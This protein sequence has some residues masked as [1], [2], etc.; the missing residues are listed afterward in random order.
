MSN[1]LY[2]VAFAGVPGLE[3]PFLLEA[4]GRCPPEDIGGPWG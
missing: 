1:I 4:K 2:L 3:V